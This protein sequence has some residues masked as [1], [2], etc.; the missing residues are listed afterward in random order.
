MKRFVLGVFLAAL[1]M[2]IWGLLY[3]GANPLP[4]TAWKRVPDEPAARAA[5]LEHFPEDGTYY[6]PGMHHDNETLAALTE[7]GP[8]AFVHMLRR[9]GR[10]MMD[11]TILVWGFVL[12]LAVALVLG[13][14]LRAAAPALPTYGARVKAAALAALAAALM[15]DLGEAVWWYIPLSWKLHQAV[16][17]FSALLIA[18]LVL[19]RFVRR[20]S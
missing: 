7:E 4:Y 15:I 13:L 18:G 20:E 5:L 12:Y 2:Y 8:V 1:A 11:P 17:D 9:E 16:F 6:V 3:W 19:A 14:L 10:P